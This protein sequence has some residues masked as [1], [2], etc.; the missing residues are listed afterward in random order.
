MRRCSPAISDANI[1]SQRVQVND[2]A[3]AQNLSSQLMYGATS[4]AQLL[5]ALAE[6]HGGVDGMWNDRNWSALMHAAD[7]CSPDLCWLLLRAGARTSTRSAHGL[8][9]ADIA[10]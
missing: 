3:D 9:A 7:V 10:Q 6:A 8:T 1:C 2:A 4:Q 5:A